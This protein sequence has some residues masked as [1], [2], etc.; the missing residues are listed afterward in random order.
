MLVR[1]FRE[2]AAD[3]FAPKKT[4]SSGKYTYFCNDLHSL[5][6]IGAKEEFVEPIQYFKTEY[7]RR[8]S[9]MAELRRIEAI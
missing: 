9:L 2:Y 6:S 7:R 1:T 5:V 3:R 4:V 8:L